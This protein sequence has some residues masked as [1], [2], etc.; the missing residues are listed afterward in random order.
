MTKT[1]LL[2]QEAIQACEVEESELR[3]FANESPQLTF[4]E[5]LRQK[6]MIF[7]CQNS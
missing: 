6:T 2:E 1:L 7:S 4:N 3:E 5:T